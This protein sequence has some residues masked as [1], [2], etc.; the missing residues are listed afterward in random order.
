MEIMTAWEVVRE[1]PN[2]REVRITWEDYD[3]RQRIECRIMTDEE[4]RLNPLMVDA[5]SR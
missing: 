2:G 5:V 1:M 3:G 4:I